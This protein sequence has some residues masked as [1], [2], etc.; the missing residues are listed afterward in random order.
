MAACFSRW[1]LV[2]AGVAVLL[3]NVLDLA[4]ILVYAR[5]RYGFRL[6][7]QVLTYA[8]AHVPI[9]IAAYAATFAHEAWL[10]ITLGLLATAASTALTAR[11]LYKKTEIWNKIKTKL[12]N[13]KNGM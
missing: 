11:T 13:K 4:V 3:S 12:K 5:L 8:A 1:G 2:G 6:S 10:G 7:R 9:G